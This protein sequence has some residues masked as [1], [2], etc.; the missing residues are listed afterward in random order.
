MI[1]EV[2]AVVEPEV[3]AV[4]AALTT[5]E[6][7]VIGGPRRR[8]RLEGQGVPAQE[9][10]P[11]AEVRVVPGQ[12]ERPPGA[13]TAREGGGVRE[14]ED[15]YRDGIGEP[16]ETAVLR[17]RFDLEIGLIPGRVVVSPHDHADVEAVRQVRYEHRAPGGQGPRYGPPRCR[18]RGRGVE[19]CV[20]LILLDQ[21]AG[22]LRVEVGIDRQDPDSGTR[23]AAEGRIARRAARGGGS[24]RAGADGDIR[25]YRGGRHRCRGPRGAGRRVREGEAPQ[26]HHR[27]DDGDRDGR[28]STG[29]IHGCSGGSGGEGGSARGRPPDGAPEGDSRKSST[30]TVV[31]S[32]RS[33]RRTRRAL[34]RARPK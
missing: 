16:T 34:G 18:A 10:V 1:R 6:R 31:P 2:L 3:E 15:R 17:L 14:R 24:R 29:A 28:P 20:N 5:G 7:E 19:R 23:Q 27:D 21:R 30:E 22:S 25:R 4:A 11:L 9:I 12:V 32:A 8:G 13:P 26:D 33:S